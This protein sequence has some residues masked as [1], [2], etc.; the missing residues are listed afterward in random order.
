M[1]K[2]LVCLVILSLA[3]EALMWLWRAGDDA[4]GG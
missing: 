4:R 2:R 1:N 3:L